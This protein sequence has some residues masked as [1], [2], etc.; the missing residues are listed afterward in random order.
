MRP[1]LIRPTNFHFGKKKNE[2]MSKYLNLSIGNLTVAEFRIF[3]FNELCANWIEF[4]LK[5]RNT[6]RLTDMAKWK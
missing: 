2:K 1:S 6:I 3:F 5:V 4:E